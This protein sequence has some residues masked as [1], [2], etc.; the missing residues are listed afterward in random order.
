MTHENIIHLGFFLVKVTEGHNQSRLDFAVALLAVKMNTVV[1]A[2]LNKHPDQCFR[3][4]PLLFSKALIMKICFRTFVANQNAAIW[5]LTGQMWKHISTKM[6]K[7]TIVYVA[8]HWTLK[9]T[10]LE[11]GR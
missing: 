2:E 11:R 10:S 7:R 6:T 9:I 5:E 4:T 1:K 8:G 3:C